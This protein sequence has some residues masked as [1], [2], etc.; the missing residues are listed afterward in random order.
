M[1]R[2][3]QVQPI[4]PGHLDALL[5]LCREHAA[6]EK[7]DFQENGQVER[8]R[9]MMFSE[10]TVLHGWIATDSGEP[11]GFMTVTIDHATWSARRFAYMDCLY[12]RESHR[13]LGLGR[14]FLDRLREFSVARQCG[15]AEWQTPPDNELGLGFY[16]RMGASAKAKVRFHYDVEERRTP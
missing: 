9:S 6:Y 7:A 2:D 12:L 11:C 5:A 8:W 14:M 10:P 3:L 15:W 16:Q 13:G 4:E 1:S